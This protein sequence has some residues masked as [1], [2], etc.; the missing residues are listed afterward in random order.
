MQPPP[1]VGRRGEAAG[2]QVLFVLAQ[3]ADTADFSQHARDFFF[4]IGTL[5]LGSVCVERENP[6]A[7]V[8]RGIHADA[9]HTVGLLALK[10]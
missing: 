5:A 6:S 10:L 9:R 2:E 4:H 1:L 3:A 7:P 8:Y